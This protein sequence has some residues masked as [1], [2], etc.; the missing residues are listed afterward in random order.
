MTITP[1]NQSDVFRIAHGFDQDIFKTA[2]PLLKDQVA[3]IFVIIQV[4]RKLYSH[5]PVVEL[6]D[7]IMRL[8][9]KICPSVVTVLMLYNTPA[10]VVLHP[11][12]FY[13]MNC[14]NNASKSLLVQLNQEPAN[15]DLASYQ[16]LMTTVFTHHFQKLTI[17]QKIE[18]I[19]KSNSIPWEQKSESQKLEFFN[20]V[21]A[22]SL[23]V[24]ATCLKVESN[25]NIN[26][27]CERET[28]ANAKLPGLI[29]LWLELTMP[30]DTN[31][32]SSQT[33]Q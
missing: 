14:I 30:S 24:T 29:N 32:G 33:L 26:A 21:Q 8:Y 2:E 17:D 20:N 23:W 10:I 7:Q 27:E 18:L 13:N 25:I 28:V 31:T 4:E 19:Q 16:K 1:L 5:L 22:C 11:P 6:I 9:L 15:G 3:R 12:L